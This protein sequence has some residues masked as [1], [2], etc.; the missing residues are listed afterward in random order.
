MTI[1]IEE[2]DFESNQI[3][4]DNEE[5]SGDLSIKNAKK[6]INMLIDALDRAKKLFNDCFYEK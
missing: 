4:V 3:L 5:L 1:V 2:N 6:C